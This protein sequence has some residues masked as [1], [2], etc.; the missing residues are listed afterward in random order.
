MKTTEDYEKKQEYLKKW[1][2]TPCS[3]I[4]RLN[5]VNMEIL[6]LQMELL[7]DLQ[8]QPISFKIPDDFFSFFLQ[9]VTS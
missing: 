7:T 9:K 2:D 4:R 8:I 6:H 5:S 3:C 1:K